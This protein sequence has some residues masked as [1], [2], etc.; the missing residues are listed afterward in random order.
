M[1]YENKVLPILKKTRN[2]LISNWG[3]AEIVGQKNDSIVSIVT[4]TD[5]DVENFV[6][7]EL[8]RVYPEINFVG[9]ESGGNRHSKKFWLMDPIDGTNHYVRGLPFCT[10]M[11]ALIENNVIKFS[12]IYDFV[13]D[14][15]YWAEKDKGAFRDGV[16]L[17]VSNRSLKNALIGWET[18]IDKEHNKK[19]IDGLYSKSI[20]LKI[21]SS[22]WEYAMIA[23]GKIDARIAFDPYGHDYDFAPGA[24]LV[25][26]AGGVVANIGSGGYD[27][28]NTDFIAA[29]PIIYKELTG[30]PGALFPIVN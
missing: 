21:L 26:E 1:D 4:K 17:A 20:L 22:G 28:R 13:N 29:N 18:H 24:L 9:E 19:K 7:E 10:S 8:K 16:K 30:G 15:M 27:F 6:S 23:S 25:K 5:I 3:V 14:H 2:I 11:V 12:A